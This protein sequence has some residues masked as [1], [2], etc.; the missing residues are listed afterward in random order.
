MSVLSHHHS[1]AQRQ[2]KLRK[3][4]QQMQGLRN[5]MEF[6]EILAQFWP[7]QNMILKM[8]R[9][10]ERLNSLNHQYQLCSG[11]QAG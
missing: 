4:Q 1:D 9:L 8:E 10:Q 5:E 2:Q 11:L 6:V 3:L 7:W